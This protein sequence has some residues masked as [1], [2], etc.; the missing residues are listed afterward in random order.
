MCKKQTSVSHSPTE[1]EV[2]SLDAGLRMD[3]IP[4]HD[5]WDMVVEVLYSSEDVPAS[6]NRSREEINIPASRNRSRNE[7]QSTHQP[8][9]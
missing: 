4:A 2:L 3:G 6:R 5:F 9:H 1:S 8:Q 7:T